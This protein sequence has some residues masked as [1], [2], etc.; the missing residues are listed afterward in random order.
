MA[1]LMGLLVAVG[2]VAL[3]HK[4]LKESIRP[5]ARTMGREPNGQ[6]IEIDDYEIVDETQNQGYKVIVL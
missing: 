2:G 4:M 1:M 5:Q 3:L 6:I